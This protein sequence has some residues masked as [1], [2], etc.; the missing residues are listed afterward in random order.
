[1]ESPGADLY[2][3]LCA[4]EKNAALEFKLIVVTR[5]LNR[6][7]LQSLAFRVSL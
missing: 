7:A 1:M 6:L 3:G 2:F 5:A 4:A